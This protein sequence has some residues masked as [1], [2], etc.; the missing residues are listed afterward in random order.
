MDNRILNEFD[1]IPSLNNIWDAAQI[2]GDRVTPIDM[3]T[4]FRNLYPRMEQV[5]KFNGRNHMKIPQDG[6]RERVETED[7]IKKKTILILHRHLNLF[8]TKSFCLP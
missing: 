8:L 5:I 3:D 4:F 7:K 1:H 2:A 6:I